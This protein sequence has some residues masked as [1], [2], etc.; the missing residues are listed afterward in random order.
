MPR[1]DAPDGP[2]GRAAVHPRPRWL[3]LAW[4]RTSSRRDGGEY[5]TVHLA[6]FARRGFAPAVVS[7]AKADGARLL[8]FEQ[9]AAD[10]ERLSLTVI[11]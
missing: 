5:W 6:L 11:R 3:G 2:R 1:V 7:A 8:T 10:L 4:P 9:L